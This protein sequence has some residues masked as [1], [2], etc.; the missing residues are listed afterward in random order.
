[1]LGVVLVLTLGAGGEKGWREYLPPWLRNAVITPLFGVGPRVVG[2]I[3]VASRTGD[4]ASGAVCTDATPCSVRRG[5]QKLNCNAGDILELLGTVSTPGVYQGVN[6][7]LNLPAHVPGKSGTDA[8]HQCTVRARNDGGVFIDG[9]FARPVFMVGG[10]NYWTFEGFDAGNATGS[11]FE[12][13]NAG[14]VT[15]G[16]TLRRICLSNTTTDQAS[17][18][19]NPPPWSDSAGTT[20]NAHVL[21]VADIN[22][23]LFE[24]VCAFG[25]GRT[26]ITEGA[27]NFDHNVNL[28]FRRVWFRYEG[29]PF[30]KDAPLGT[31]PFLP[32]GCPGTPTVQYAYST[33]GPVLYENI[34][35]VYAPEQFNL[36]TFGSHNCGNLGVRFQPGMDARNPHDEMYTFKGAIVY[37]GDNYLAV[38]QTKIY[39]HETWWS[40]SRR[41]GTFVDVFMDARSQPLGSPITLN[42]RDVFTAA[43]CSDN[44]IDRITA[45][46]ASGTSNPAYFNHGGSTSNTNDCTSLGACPNFYTG[47]GPGTGARN[48]FEYTNGV[49][50][51]NAAT[52]G[53]WP[54]RMDDRIKAALARARAAGRGG[55][56]LAG[57]AGAGYAA[58]TV[59]SE[60][61]SRYGTIPAACNRGGTVFIPD[62]PIVTDFPSTPVVDAFDR[63]NGPLGANWLTTYNPST[64]FIVQSNQAVSPSG[65]FARAQWTPAT[66]AGPHEVYASWPTAPTCC[67]L[68]TFA[69]TAGS[70]N[71]Q[72]RLRME[73]AGSGNHALRV[74]KVDGAGEETTKLGPIDLGTQI[75]G[76]NHLFGVRVS[77]TQTISVYWKYTDGVTYRVG[78]VID[79]SLPTA[80]TV[81]GFAGNDPAVLNDFGGGTCCGG[82]VSPA[83][84]GRFGNLIPRQ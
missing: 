71:N 26:A 68:L 59:T 53:L 58:G 54:W 60:I 62:F 25:T 20:P 28:V 83:N 66:F 22:D 70:D 2:T 52:Q 23:S 19:S 47:T 42:C 33:L 16:I 51:T 40:D 8:A 37:G 4:D 49:L 75:S 69:G 65:A 12:S 46:R 11:V 35:A 32:N 50:G 24:D 39:A 38:D 7:M 63:A 6:Y 36:A 5:V 30:S 56:P 10:N 43:E 78:T 55:S 31:P 79:S 44:V 80:N 81:I 61:V 84:V 27:T 29:F 74:T 77:N 72:Y 1:L 13:F 45:I 9:Q 76:A 82:A 67:H 73:T 15:T 3:Y 18:S 14:G 17:G 57:G 48:C 64:P 34:I 21:G 41:H